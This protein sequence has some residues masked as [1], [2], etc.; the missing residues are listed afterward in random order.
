NH[1]GPG[2]KKQELGGHRPAEAALADLAAGRHRLA[3]LFGQ[4]LAP[5][6]V[7]PWNR[8][9]PEVA[10]RLPEIGFRG[11]S[12]FGA[13]DV[14]EPSGITVVNTHVDPI[15]W[16]GTRSLADAGA[17]IRLVTAHVESCAVGEAPPA[18]GLL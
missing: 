9:A 15:D 16:H 14:T 12:T 2:Q 13:G 8:I 4:D 10:A 3:A 7:P 11:L 18:L 1:A 5:V 6:L 17:L